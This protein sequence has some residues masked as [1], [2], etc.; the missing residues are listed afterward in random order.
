[1]EFRRVLFR[2]YDP[3]RAPG[4]VNSSAKIWGQRTADNRFA[5]VYNP[6]EFRWPLAVSTSDDGLTYTDLLLING[7]IT[8]MRYGG[9]Y[10]SYGPQYPRGIQ[11][12]N[13]VPPDNNMWVTYSM[14]KE[15]M[16][17]AKVPVP[18]TSVVAGNVHDDFTQTRT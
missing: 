10:K 2:A 7:D 5:T 1:L 15:D 13:G 11:E 4:F 12:G 14:N 6:T 8:T 3:L 18:V 17:V 9:N 16:W